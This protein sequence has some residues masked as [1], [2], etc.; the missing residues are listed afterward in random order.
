M[1]QEG[2]ISW[3]AAYFRLNG[4]FPYNK[5]VDENLKIFNTIGEILEKRLHDFT[6]LVGERIS[7]A[8]LFAVKVVIGAVATVLVNH[9]N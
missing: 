8:D 3:A 1:N 6:Y 9:F 7:Y 2:V 4:R 5:E